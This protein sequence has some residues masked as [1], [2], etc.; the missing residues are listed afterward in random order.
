[1][2][3]ITVAD[4]RR[5]ERAQ[6]SCAPIALV[7]GHN[8]EGKT[9]LS[10]AVQAALTGAA[11]P[12]RLKLAK[13]DAAAVVRAQQKTGSVVLAGDTGTARVDWPECKFSTD[14]D[15]PTSSAVAAGVTS[16]D[17]QTGAAERVT[18]MAPY[19]NALPTEADLD[20][21]LTQR[22]FSAESIAAVWA[23]I[24]R[25]GWDEMAQHYETVGRDA[26][27]DWAKTAGTNWGD[28]KAQKWVP[29]G[30]TP[31][32]DE[33]S[34][35]E[36]AHRIE[37]AEAALERAIAA[38]AVDEVTRKRLEETAGGLA[39]WERTRDQAAAEEAA[40]D[41][42]IGDLE[43]RR[44]QLPKPLSDRGTPCPH[45]GKPVRISLTVLEK[46]EP[47]DPAENH[48]R[49]TALTALDEQLIPLR[50]RRGTAATIRNSAQAHIAAANE[51]Q[52]QLDRLGADPRIG[53]AAATAAVRA[54]LD[55]KRVERALIVR[56]AEARESLRLVQRSQILVEVLRPDGLRRQTLVAA[57]EHFNHTVLAPITGDADLPTVA[58][59]HD[60]V[61]SFGGCPYPLLSAGHLY[62]M[63]AVLQIAMARLDR[64][65]LV[66]FD[67]A[68]VLDSNGRNSLFQMIVNSGLEALVTMTE[69]RG[70]PV[71]DLAEADI[72]GTWRMAGG[73]ARPI[74]TA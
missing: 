1:M 3:G 67:G 46:H 2:T 51:A 25:R 19:L 47:L 61:P 10:E 14:G 58:L 70:V 15:P 39:E 40:V 30:W 31:D 5:V 16:L 37:I 62:L 9:S 55:Q 43:A 29:D 54:E 4:Y 22:N 57:V 56:F 13:K 63:R 42:E 71:P 21:E 26:K 44:A 11:L 49:S 73:I 53:T 65:R 36:A 48:K 28:A 50:E 33:I 59:D 69:V 32:L 34:E 74:G 17:Q 24:A 6:I 12:G 23:E 20:R 7:V 27:R 38:Q 60:L 8:G 66:V 41:R 72:G 64:S 52:L 45:C 35:A 68:D 18:L